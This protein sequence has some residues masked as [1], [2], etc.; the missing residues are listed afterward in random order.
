MLGHPCVHEGQYRWNQAGPLEKSESSWLAVPHLDEVPPGAPVLRVL[1]DPYD[2]VHSAMSKGFLRHGA[3][4]YD[5]YVEHHRPDIMSAGD[6]LGRVIRWVALWDQPMDQIHHRRLHTGDIRSVVEALRYA[7]GAIATGKE[8]LDVLIEAGTRT[9]A[10]PPDEWTPGPT[11]D[12]IR[13]HPDGALI[14]ARAERFGYKKW[15]AR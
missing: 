4:A 12:Q 14:E 5:M 8:V 1:R 9:N 3:D 6:H 11:I 10:V 15:E 7:T 2:V 13:N